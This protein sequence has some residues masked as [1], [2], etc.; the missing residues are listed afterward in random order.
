MTL[1][2]LAE[3]SQRDGRSIVYLRALCAAGRV[4][5]ARKIGRD[6]LVPERAVIPR[7]RRGRPKQQGATR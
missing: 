1:L 6:W 4:R 5:G 3:L 2:T 7:E